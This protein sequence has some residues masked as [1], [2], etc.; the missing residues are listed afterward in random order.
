MQWLCP[1]CHRPVSVHLSRCPHCEG[2]AAE[3]APEITPGS[4]ADSAAA[5]PADSP[6]PDSSPRTDP[7][8]PA[9]PPSSPASPGGRRL[10]SAIDVISSAFKRTTARLFHPWR[11]ACWVRYALLCLATG[12][13][14]GFGSSTGI[15]NLNIPN[16]RLAM[17]MMGM[18][19]STPAS[20]WPWLQSP[21]TLAGICAGMLILG[22]LWIYVASVCRFILFDAV[23]ADRCRL[24][25]GWRRWRTAGRRL[26][27]WEL[28]F[29]FSMLAILLV[30]IGTPLLLAW[31]GG[32]F[33]DS[34]EHFGMLL[35]GGALL[36]LFAVLFLLAAA[37]VNTLAIDF[38]VPLLAMEHLRVTEAWRRLLGMIRREKA[39]YLGYILMKIV[40]TVGSAL[41]F[42]IVTFLV[43]LIPIILVTVILVA[44][45]LGGIHW[46]AFTI[47]AAILFGIVAVLTL[48]FAMALIS[49]P[50]MVF[51]EAYALH[52]F[53]SRYEP[54]GAALSDA[55]MSG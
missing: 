55:A 3:F 16:R 17:R 43:L 12:E 35:G 47:G 42:G 45:P 48:V 39:A 20:S 32:I 25:E 21:L 23:L 11:W 9:P 7:A 54:L 50:S 24:R 53:G 33:R 1:K 37:L 18:F 52:F 36:L 10:L 19:Q 15:G 6:R 26:F 34:R 41:I 14:T 27:G 22:L 31:R 29:G 28:A 8:L 51:F 4:R 30:V 5:N 49:A 13:L 38:L 40:F 2:S 44:V 46:N